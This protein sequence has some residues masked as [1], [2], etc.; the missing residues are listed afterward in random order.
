MA[1]RILVSQPGIEPVLPIVEAQ[2]LNHWTAREV[3]L[4]LWKAEVIPHSPTPS[5]FLSAE[6]L[7][8]EVRRDCVLVFQVAMCCPNLFCTYLISAPF[9]SKGGQ[10]SKLQTLWLLEKDW[11]STALVFS[12]R[13]P[14]CGWPFISAATVNSQPGVDFNSKRVASNEV[15]WIPLAPYSPPAGLFFFKV[16]F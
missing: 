13:A 16:Y 14:A 3:S 12:N 8:P 4:Q 5:H 9:W 7:P 15:F 1:C 11:Y 10:S 2:S 6:S